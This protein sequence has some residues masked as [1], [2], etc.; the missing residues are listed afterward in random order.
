M[1]HHDQIDATIRYPRRRLW[2]LLIG[3]PALLLAAIAYRLIAG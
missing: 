1:P 2:A 3:V